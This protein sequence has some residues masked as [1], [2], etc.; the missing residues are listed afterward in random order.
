[1]P[2]TE[3]GR[4]RLHRKFKAG[5]VLATAAVC[6]AILTPRATDWYLDHLTAVGPVSERERRYWRRF[7]ERQPRYTQRCMAELG[8]GPDS[9]MLRRASRNLT[10]ALSSRVFED[11]RDL[12]YRLR[13]DVRSVWYHLS[14][15]TPVLGPDLRSA[16]ELAVE[17][18]GRVLPGTEQ[19]T[20]SWGCRGPEPR[21]DAPLRVLVLGDSLMQGCMVGEE[22]TPPRRLEARLSGSS[23]LDAGVMG[24]SPEQYYYSLLRFADRFRPHA[25]VVSLCANDADPDDADE[26]CGWLRKIVRSCGDRGIGC[27]LVPTPPGVRSEYPGFPGLLRPGAVPPGLWV[28]FIAA[29]DAR[30]RGETD[31]KKNPL[32]NGRLNDGHLSPPG[33]ELWAEVVAPHVPDA[34]E[35]A[36]S[37]G[38][39]PG[40][41]EPRPRIGHEAAPAR[42]LP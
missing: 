1:M 37:S 40:T 6:L 5:I 31:W 35:R 9:R 21:T 12:G 22:Q 42:P 33:A 25:V 16:R 2:A 17:G 30:S 14:T 39:R 23:V 24:Y 3:D 32:F 20:N 4:A 10:L 15:Y 8:L 34:V 29:F 18:G 41:P 28:D 36:R 38:G 11:D 7:F 19:V 13:P 26:Q 27:L